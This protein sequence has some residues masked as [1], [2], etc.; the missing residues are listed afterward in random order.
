MFAGYEA[1]TNRWSMGQSS[2]IPEH[3]SRVKKVGYRI[4]NWLRPINF[5]LRTTNFDRLAKNRTFFVFPPNRS[6]Q[7][8]ER[9]I[10][11]HYFQVLMISY[12]RN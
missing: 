2:Q 11:N 4:A 1:I 3:L 6:E 5:L 9:K 8:L 12:L 7:T 10:T